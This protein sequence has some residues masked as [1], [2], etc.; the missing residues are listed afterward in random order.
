M[1]TRI[2]ATSLCDPIRPMLKS[3]KLLCSTTVCTSPSHRRFGCS[4]AG[5]G[6]PWCCS[7]RTRS[8]TFVSSSQQQAKRGRLLSSSCADKIL[9][10]ACVITSCLPLCSCFATTM[11]QRA[12]PCTSKAT[13]RPKRTWPPCKT[14]QKRF[15]VSLLCYSSCPV[16]F[17]RCLCHKRS[18]FA[19]FYT[20]RNLFH[21]N[22][23]S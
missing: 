11:A 16:G 17:K 7:T 18:E 2:P 22:S 5:C 23:L 13:R 15:T 8:R 1:V 3:T 4:I 9:G 14:V 19:N 12:S 21:A 20:T 6:R 10:G